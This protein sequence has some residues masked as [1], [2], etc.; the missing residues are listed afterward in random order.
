M[1]TDAK[2]QEH[3]RRVA[4]GLPGTISVDFF[5]NP[6]DFS[7]HKEILALLDQL[8]SVADLESGLLSVH[9]SLELTRLVVFSSR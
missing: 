3:Y 6:L 1:L 5:G 8:S 2:A 9:S 4:G 7:W